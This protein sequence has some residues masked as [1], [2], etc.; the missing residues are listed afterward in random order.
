MSLFGEIQG[1][2]P[3]EV[4]QLMADFNADQDANKVSLGVGA[5]RDDAGKPWVLPVVK[6]VERQLAEAVEADQLNHEYL[7]VLGLAAFSEASTKLILGHDS[8]AVAEGRAFGTQSLSGTGSI[9]IGAEFICRQLGV[10]SVLV[11]DPTWGNHNLIFK[12]AGFTEIRKYRYWS[13]EQTG[14]DFEGMVEDLKAAPEGSAVILHAVAHNPTGID[15]TKDQWKTLAD[16]IQEKKLIP[17]FD[18]AYQGFA[19]GD[20]DADAW[21]P[22]YFVNERNME[23][24]IS[25]SFAKNFGLYNER[26]GNLVIV[27]NDPSLATN[28]KA[29]MTLI[30]R[31]MYSNPPAHGARIIEKVLNDRDG[32][33]IEWT[34]NV[35]TMAGRIKAMRQGLRERLEKLQTPGKWNHITDQIGMFSFTGLKPEMVA[36]LIKEKHIYL[37]KNGRISVAGLTPS[38]LD[39][40]AESMHQ[41]VTKFT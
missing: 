25:Q 40:V 32:L 18:S 26:P 30:A 10:K 1:A 35:K 38:N 36:F 27:V 13:A 39:Y 19:S 33:Y 6:K 23:V 37:L 22:R 12:L 8:S 20:L 15:P 14:F 16:I 4:F 17:F 28:V 24:F 2:A 7:P 21:A 5:Y 34:E 41:A 11:S 29:Q 9:R 31:G 3:V